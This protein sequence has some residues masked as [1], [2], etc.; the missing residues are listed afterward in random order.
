MAHTRPPVSVPRLARRGRSEQ[1]TADGS[2]PTNVLDPHA[3]IGVWTTASRRKVCIRES[4]GAD[5]E[6][7]PF[8]QLSRL[9]NPLVNQ[10][11]IALPEKDLWNSLP[12]T[13]DG[14][15]FL[16]RFSNPELAQLLPALYPGVFPN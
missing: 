8:V 6:S 14:T 1:P 4:A 10:V 11:I 16:A 12:P 7:G 5:T 15:D 3:V 9:G 13:S 2:V